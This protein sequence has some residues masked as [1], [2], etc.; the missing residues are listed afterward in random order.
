M[1]KKKKPI[2]TK[3]RCRE[4]ALK[5]T[6]RKDFL[7]NSA[8]AY[9]IAQRKGWLEEVCAGLLYVQKPVGYW[10]KSRCHSLSKKFQHRND[11]YKNDPTAY[12]TAQRHGWL[13]DICSH[14]T[15]QVLPRHYWTKT[16]VTKEALKY[17]NR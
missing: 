11:F 10:T 4:E 12:R 2:W 14:M 3:E 16:L 7:N 1:K 17:S 8:S 13:D 5:Y 15:Y 9:R 6:T